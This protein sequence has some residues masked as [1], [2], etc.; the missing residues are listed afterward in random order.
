MLPGSAAW[1]AASGAAAVRQSTG[2]LGSVNSL[3]GR[4][5]AFGA[6]SRGARRADGDIQLSAFGVERDF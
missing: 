4:M 2:D 6:P 5:V 3:V 1:D